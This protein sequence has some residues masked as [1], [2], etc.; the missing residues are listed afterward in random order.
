MDEFSPLGRTWVAELLPDGKI[1]E[2]RVLASDFGIVPQDAELLAGGGSPG[3]EAFKILDILS[4]RDQGVRLH[5]VGLNAAPVLLLAGLARDL[6]QGYEKSLEAI[7]S[8]AALEKLQ[9]WVVHQN[10][11]PSTGGKTLARLLGA[12]HRV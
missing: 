3:E 6:G 12:R 5:T 10:R 7:R 8:G 9:A 1:L 4:G 2:Y 11:K